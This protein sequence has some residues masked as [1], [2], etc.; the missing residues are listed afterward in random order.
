[1]DPLAAFVAVMM[2]A[3]MRGWASS[4][5]IM[6]VIAL[7]GGFHENLLVAPDQM[8]IDLAGCV[9]IPLDES[10]LAPT[11]L[12]APWSGNSARGRVFSRVERGKLDPWCAR[13]Q[14]SRVARGLP[15][16]FNSSSDR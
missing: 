6:A 1:M 12:G 10:V 11:I 14:G 5:G 15:L 7:T 3:R 2:A 9:E 13:D 16:V 8:R 4:S